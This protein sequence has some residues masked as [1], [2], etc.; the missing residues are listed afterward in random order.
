MKEL[1]AIQQSMYVKTTTITN[2]IKSFFASF[3]LNHSIS[4]FSVWFFLPSFSRLL[5]L[6]RQAEQLKHKI[7][8]KYRHSLFLC[9]LSH[10]HAHTYQYLQYECKCVD[11]QKLFASCSSVV[12]KYPFRVFSFVYKEE[13]NGMHCLFSVQIALWNNCI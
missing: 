12:L 4:F 6:H 5:L 8:R 2:N 9:V 7:N 11:V 3:S 10:T 1:T 13:K